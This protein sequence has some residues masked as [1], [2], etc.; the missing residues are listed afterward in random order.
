MPDRPAALN[1]DLL[2]RVADDF[3]GAPDVVMGT[4]FRSPG[5]RVGDKIFAFLGR[6]GRL[7]VKLPRERADAFVG[8][9]TAEQVVMGERRMREWFAFPAQDDRAA[10]LALWRDVAREAHRYVDA[11]RRRLERDEAEPF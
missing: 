2:E 1:R 6:D 4:M 10:T 7:I 11:L 9:G 8:A 5:L 3:D